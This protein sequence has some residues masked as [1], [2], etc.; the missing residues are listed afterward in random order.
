[1]SAPAD[2]GLHQHTQVAIQMVQ[3][4]EKNVLVLQL[5]H[6]GIHDLNS[7]QTCR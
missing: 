6:T 7:W 2:T 4:K 1:M 5:S 3:H